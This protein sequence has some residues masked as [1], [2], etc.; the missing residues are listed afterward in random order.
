MYFSTVYVFQ[1]CV[2]ISVLCMYFSTVYVFQYCVCISDVCIYKGKAY[3]QGQKWDDGCVK[4]CVCENGMT[5]YYT[6]TDR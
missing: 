4:V 6:C 3:T 2:C 1:Y 5:G